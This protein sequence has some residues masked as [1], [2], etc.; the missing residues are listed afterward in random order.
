LYSAI[1]A[2]SISRVLP[3]EGGFIPMFTLVLAYFV[4]GERLT[5]YQYIAFV[6]LVFGAVTILSISKYCPLCLASLYCSF[7]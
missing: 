6:F 4:L 3:I 2:T 1:Q 7:S 5:E